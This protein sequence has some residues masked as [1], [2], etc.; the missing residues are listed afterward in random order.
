MRKKIPHKNGNQF[1]ETIDFDPCFATF[2]SK[3]MIYDAFAWFSKQFV[4]N[5]KRRSS[6][7]GLP[8]QIQQFFNQQIHAQFAQGVTNRNKY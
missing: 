7:I 8:S 1:S 6:K 2:G 4:S 3:S 5:L